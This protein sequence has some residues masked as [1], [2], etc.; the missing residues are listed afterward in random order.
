MEIKGALVPID[1]SAGSLAALSY[2]RQLVAKD[3]EIYLLHVID[4]DFIHQVEEAHV[5]ECRGLG[6]SLRRRAEERLQALI[7]QAA[8]APRL[9]YMIVKG[10]PFAEILR[11]AADLDFDL[12][13]MTTH[14]GRQG[15][16][17]LLFGSVSERVLRASTVPVL[18]IPL[19][20]EQPLEAS[21]SSRPAQTAGETT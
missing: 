17:Q 15:V 6:E 8:E 1:F 5:L 21:T 7:G 13:V 18:C 4:E 10:K 3:G 19:P 12:I 16:E 11:V 14:G 9:E 2:A 20:P